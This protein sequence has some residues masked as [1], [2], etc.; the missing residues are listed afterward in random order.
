LHEAAAAGHT[1]AAKV[2]LSIG[3]TPDVKDKVKML[4]FN[5]LTLNAKP[6]I[7]KKLH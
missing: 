2:L 4:P 7:I 5:T 1:E 3:A 6:V